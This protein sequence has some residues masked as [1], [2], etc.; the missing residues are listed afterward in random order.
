MKL[1][2]ISESVMHL[3]YLFFARDNNIKR[4][5]KIE[6]R[7][8]INPIEPIAGSPAERGINK[9]YKETPG[10]GKYVDFYV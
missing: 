9:D 2:E 1:E 6:E 4:T 3:G 8:E 5:E 10:L 7:H